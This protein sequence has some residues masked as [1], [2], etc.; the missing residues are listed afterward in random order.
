MSIQFT[1]SQT[2]YA[3]GVVASITL[4]T[5]LTEPEYAFYLFKDGERIARRNYSKE[6][7]VF[8]P[9]DDV[10]A[11]SYKISGFVLE[12][13]TEKKSSKYSKPID[14]DPT[15]LPRLPVASK[16]QIRLKEWGINCDLWKCPDPQYITRSENL[17]DDY[18][19]VRTDNS[20]FI[21]SGKD[22]RNTSAP[23]EKWVFLGDSFLECLMLPE[24]MRLPARIEA[25]INNDMNRR[26]QCLNGG[27]SGATTL[28]LLNVLLN[29]VVPLSPARVIFLVPTNDARVLDLPGGYWRDDKLH[30][31][32]T[33]VFT[34]SD[35][36]Y[37]ER[38]DGR[39]LSGLLELV[40]TVCIHWR[41]H[42]TLAT[43]PHRHVG[44]AHDGWL[45]RRFPAEPHFKKIAKQRNNVNSE[46]RKFASTMSLPL[47]DLEKIAKDYKKYS[48]DDLH[49]TAQGAE[50][51]S[52]Q[53]ISA[54]ESIY[55]PS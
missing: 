1:V 39:S 20:G 18:Y 53:F 36:P 24:S 17:P 11:G 30:S 51:I 48:Y 37:K 32:F 35:E 10:A 44:Y 41:I 23:S 55:E 16:R 31:P 38:N 5:S 8:F 14:I 47:I 12:K 42:L 7:T 28:H 40:H 2:F 46:V 49:L 50:L 19:R 22:W 25:A 33:P 13:D 9:I 3:T 27:Y 52:A 21:I 29:K 15:R 45:Q 6:P 54:L 26:V 4:E 43:T 34:Q